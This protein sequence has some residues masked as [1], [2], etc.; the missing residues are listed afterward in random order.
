MS[1]SFYSLAKEKIPPH[2]FQALAGVGW[3]LEKVF[4]TLL[5]IAQEIG[6]IPRKEDPL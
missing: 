5:K 1:P 3:S 2:V 6:E 4:D